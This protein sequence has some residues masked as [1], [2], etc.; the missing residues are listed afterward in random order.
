[1]AID[2]TDTAV[3]KLQRALQEY[4]AAFPE[5][6]VALYRWSP[7]SIRIR[8]IDPRFEGMGFFARHDEVWNYF[9]SLPDEVVGQINLL[10]TP[11]PSE[12]GSSR[13]NYLF[14]NPDQPSR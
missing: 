3:E 2:L 1:M 10:I 12:L 13:K 6:Q 7:H 5:A 8:V 9:R 4:Q 14:E 11:A